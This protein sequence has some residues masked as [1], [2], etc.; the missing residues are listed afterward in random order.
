MSRPN[1]RLFALSLACLL[2]AAPAPAEDPQDFWNSPALA[3]PYRPSLSED[4]RVAGLSRLWAEVKFNFA[5]FDLVPDLDWDALYMAYLPRVRQETSTLAYYRLLMEMVAKLRDGHSNVFLPNELADETYADPP[6]RTAVI[7]GRPFISRVLAASLEAEGF[8][9]GLEIV[10]ID[11]IPVKQYAETR[12]APYLSA[13]TPQDLAVRTYEHFLL[14]GSVSAP[15]ELTLQP[16]SGEAFRRKVA[17][18]PDAEWSR[19]GVTTPP[20]E[21]RMLPGNIAYVALNRFGN[22]AAA[23]QFEARFEEIA[24][25]DALILDVRNNGGGNSSVGYRVLACLTDKPFQTSRWHTRDYR[26]TLRAWGEAEGTYGGDSEKVQPSGT[27][28]FTKPVVVLTG[29]RT[30]S[31]AEDFAVAFDAMKRG[32]IV[33]EPTGGSTGQPLTF[34]LP[35]GGSARVCTKRDTYPD[36]KEFVGVGVQPQVLVRPTIEDFRAGRDTVLEAALELLK[37]QP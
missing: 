35:G 12:V 6:L 9:P 21:L 29:P 7:E 26:P 32:T 13:S 17:R 36:G 24:K 31:A 15:V 14:S 20:L 22:D 1:A 28:L 2:S 8:R 23:E 3:T 37:K 25:A 16:A 4:E 19:L 10:A 34:K 18:L 33:G 30:F 11:G 5:N 27:R